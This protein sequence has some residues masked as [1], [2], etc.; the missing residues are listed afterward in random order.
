MLFDLDGVLVD[1]TLAVDRAWRDWAERQGFGTDIILEIV[2]GRR[3]AETIRL[4][5]PDLDTESET[6]GLERLKA[7]NMD[8]MEHLSLSLPEAFVTTEDVVNGKPAPEAYLIVAKPLG[9]RPEDCVVIED[10]PSG[11]QAARAAGMSMIATATTHKSGDLSEADAV[12]SA[13]ASIDFI[14]ERGAY[15]VA[16]GYTPHLRPKVDG[17]LRESKCSGGIRHEVPSNGPPARPNGDP[18]RRLCKLRR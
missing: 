14:V 7:S 3:P 1:S 18:G 5:T 16:S 2:H 11:I 9:A 6:L 10:A 8:N 12:V 4:I 15:P 17:W 13:L